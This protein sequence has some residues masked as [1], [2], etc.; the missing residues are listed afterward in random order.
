MNKK[1]KILLNTILF[2]AILTVA[3]AV[4]GILSSRSSSDGST[5]DFDPFAEAVEPIAPEPLTYSEGSVNAHIA[6]TFD[7]LAIDTYFLRVQAFPGAGVPT[8]KGGFTATD[9]EVI[10]KLR[11]VNCPTACRTPESR[12]RPHVEVERE[13]KRWADGMH[14]VTT[15]LSLNNSLRLSR[16]AVVDGTL[17]ADIE[18]YLGNQWHDLRETLIEDGFAKPDTQVWNWGTKTPTPR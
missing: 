5:Q 3:S 6:Y 13:R 14:F 16:L 17:V 1:V 4:L 9:V 7:V 8:I 10:V 2:L 11:G 15:L 12:E 18:Y